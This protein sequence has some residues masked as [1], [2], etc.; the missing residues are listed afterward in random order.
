MTMPKDPTEARVQ[1]LLVMLAPSE[2][3]EIESRASSFSMD[4]STYVRFCTIGPG[5]PL[6]VRTPLATGVHGAIVAGGS[7]RGKRN[8]AMDV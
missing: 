8:S 2:R 5:A 1:R 6:L 7:S 4:M 3:E